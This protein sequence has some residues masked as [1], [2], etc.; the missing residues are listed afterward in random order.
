MKIKVC[1]LKYA[2]NVAGILECKPN[3]IGFIFYKKSLRF[4]ESELVTR[5]TNS[6]PTEVSTVGVFVN[7]TVEQVIKIHHDYGLSYVQLHGDESVEDCILLKKENVRV[8]KAFQ[9]DD[10]FDFDSIN[11]F[12]P[13]VDLFLF[14]TK[15]NQRGGTG[16][17]FN[18]SLLSMYTGTVP[19]ILSGGITSEDVNAIINLDHRQL[20]GVDINSRFEIGPGMK[21]VKLVSEFIKNLRD[22]LHN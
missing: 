20:Y 14:D 22:G 11:P 17:K 4:V 7:E 19:F 12:M 21:D 1:G 2:E 15:G 10:D 6:I 9:I 13:Y 3:L 18:W 5:I 16:K 8:I